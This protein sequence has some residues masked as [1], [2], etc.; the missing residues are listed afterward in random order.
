[1]ENLELLDG[2][3]KPVKPKPIGP[4]EMPTSETASPGSS[5]EDLASEP[6]EKAP[7]DV[8]MVTATEKGYYTVRENDSLYDIAGRKGV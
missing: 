4:I 8:K 7:E 1:M 6:V 5:P 3:S 2:K